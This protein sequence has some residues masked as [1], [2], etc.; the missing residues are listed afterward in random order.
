MKVIIKPLGFIVLMTAL[1]SLA[2]LVI[3]QTRDA[4][5]PTPPSQQVAANPS[6][7]PVEVAP[8]PQASPSDGNLL[9][10][11][12]FEEGFTAITPD[13][14]TNV[15]RITGTIAG[16]GVWFDN[17]SWAD[18]TAEYAPDRTIFHG[19]ECSQ[20]VD[21][22]TVRAGQI[23]LA[24]IRVLPT[25]RDYEVSAWVRTSKPTKITLAM[26]VGERSLLTTQDLPAGPEWREVSVKTFRRRL[27][28]GENNNTWVMLFLREPGI[29]YWIDDVKVSQINGS[30][31][32]K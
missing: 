16:S 32:A 30:Q 14:K 3:R 15:A 31:A 18:I 24:Q 25:D 8:T 10:S 6:L 28:E 2:F 20:R 27:A 12:G 22:K 5:L 11:G 9:T 21:L 4:S 17:S 19:G 7:P 26:R 29:T 23:Q 13:P 1:A